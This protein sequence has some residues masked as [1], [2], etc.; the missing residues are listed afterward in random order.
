M[1]ATLC[2]AGLD[3]V[4]K[5]ASTIRGEDRPDGFRTAPKLSPSRRIVTGG[6]R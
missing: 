6:D 2:L 5:L 4:S 1:S 3:A